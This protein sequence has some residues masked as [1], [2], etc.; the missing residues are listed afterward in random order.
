MKYILV[1]FLYAV[2]SV[3]PINL[4]GT[5]SIADLVIAI[6][7]IIYLLR[8]NISLQVY[9]NEDLLYI[10][11]L[12]LILLFI[13]I[14]TEILVN[15]SI[16][17]SMKGIAITVL[18]YMKILVLWPLILKNSR[19]IFWLFLWLCLIKII[20]T[21]PESEIST[22]DML[23]GEEYSFF[24]FR[25]APRIGE[26]LI[27]LSLWKPLKKYL[28]FLFITIGIFCIVLGARSTGL[29][30]FL[31]GLIGYFYQHKKII[32]RKIL[33][34]WGIIG[35]FI[36]YGLFIIYVNA[37]LSGDI[38]SGNSSIQLQ[39]IENPYN[40]LYVLLS[41]RTES[42]A[43]LAA[44]SDSPWIGWGAWAKDPD[45][46]YHRIQAN[47]QGET[48]NTRINYN[49]IIPA[50]SVLLQ[51]GV[52]NGIFALIIMGCILYFFIATIYFIVPTVLYN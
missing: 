5:L 28:S 22:T 20:T 1:F 21:N 26:A 16:E 7:F 27:L 31:T 45:W 50:H 48:F 12:Y 44:I 41:G 10:T 17:N 35:S 33:L 49:N 14:F 13:Q 4:I 3:I 32:K 52:H 38:V 6:F 40:P 29:M 25:I 23:S 36:C 9:K 39:K 51:T 11:K 18:S 8:G 19:N 43:S 15:N 46:K 47:F 30:I 34:R 24:K 42:P 2:G 37:V